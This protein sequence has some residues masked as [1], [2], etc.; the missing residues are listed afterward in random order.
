MRSIAY[1]GNDFSEICSAQVT[2]RSLNELAV[3]AMR[4]AGRPGSVI[5]SV[6]VPPEDVSVR[7]FLD[8]GFD[9]G[10]MGL[11]EARHRLRSWLMQ[12]HGGELVLPDEPELTYRDALLVSAGNWSNLFEDGSCD[13]TFTLFD[14]VA[15]G[16]DRVERTGEFVVG[17]TFRTAPEFRLVAEAGGELSVASNVTGEVVALDHDFN[18]GEAVV[19]GCESQTVEIGGADARD[20][21]V[22]GS[23]F[24]SLPPGAT[25]L[26]FAGCSHAETRFAERWL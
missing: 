19:I 20:V 12:P 2:G 21:V 15:Y 11:A 1:A 18:G 14:P 5:S 24:F 25:A 7:L 22:L 17:G 9:P 16:L 26:T 13:L 8:P 6:W 10:P 3:E 4:V 23:D